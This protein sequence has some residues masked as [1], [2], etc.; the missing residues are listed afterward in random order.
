MTGNTP[1][2]LREIAD[3]NRAYKFLNDSELR[4]RRLFESARDGILILDAE[5]G[6]IIDVNPFLIDLLGYS[7]EQFLERR[8]WEIGSFKDFLSN[9]DN[10]FELKQKGYIRYEDL[11]LQTSDGQRRDVEFISNVY[12]E[13]N[14]KVIQCNI[15]DITERKKVEKNLDIEQKRAK[16]YLDMGGTIFLSVDT[17]GKV[18]LI[19]KAGCDILGFEKDYIVGKNWFDH[20]V[21]ES[22]K[23]NTKQFLENGM[24]NE[25]EA[26]MIRRNPVIDAKGREHQIIWRNSVLRDDKG[27]II[28]TLSSGIDITK[29]NIVEELLKESE[30]KYSSYIENAPDGVFVTDE[31]GRYIEV[32]K[33]ASTITG[34][35]INELLGM[36]IQ[37]ITAKESEEEGLNHFH[38]LLK[39]GFSNGDLQYRH[40][41]GSNRWWRVTA[42]KLTETRFLGFVKDIT[43]IKKSEERL[44]YCSYHD[45]LTGL[46]NRRFFEEEIIRIDTSRNLPLSIAI[47]DINGLKLVNDSFGH[48]VGDDFL[49]K[50]AE[51]IRKSCR[52]NDIIARIGGDEF[53]IIFP[54]TDDFEATKIIHDIKGMASKEKISIIPLNISVGVDTKK[55]DAQSVMEIIANAENYMY[56]HKLYEHASVKSKT[57]DIIMNTLFEKSERESKHSKRVSEICEAIAT[58]MSFGM[59]DINKM[60]IA[61]LVHDIGKI[62]VSEAILNKLDRL[63]DNEWKIMK[64]HPEAS[65]RILSSANEFAELAQY[66][67]EHHEKWDGSGYPKGLKGKEISVEA[68]I[69][70]IADA[71]DAMT[72]ERTY[73]EILCEEKAVDEIRRCSGT[74]FDPNIARVFIEKVLKKEW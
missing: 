15:R 41:N 57:I 19:N 69:I 49:K 31:K 72:S 21:P 60:K 24:M 66:V 9:R 62:G 53:I 1:L 11:P 73:G 48:D 2:L 5:T 43:D 34:R 68:R 23:N 64:R 50:A 28:G 51:I 14:H 29:Q 56:R 63:D 17:V 59:H 61:G 13:E 47:A 36:S 37:D 46:Y 44:I 25:S 8:V 33:A 42:A 10:F 70:A 71:Y 35:S 18:M 16:Q 45:Q 7:K 67:Y 20:F 32:N 22:W 6:M 55:N 26:D 4:Y 3:L 65:W 39:T 12:L 40:K 30:K 74:Q 38:T 52:T 54:K 58:E 27:I